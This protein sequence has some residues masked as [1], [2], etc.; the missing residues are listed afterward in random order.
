MKRLSEIFG[1]KTYLEASDFILVNG[2]IDYDRLAFE[3][4][5]SIRAVDPY[6]PESTGERLDIIRSFLEAV[7]N[8]ERGNL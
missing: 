2:Q 1:G 7:T 6:R 3:L 8:A 4:D 5:C